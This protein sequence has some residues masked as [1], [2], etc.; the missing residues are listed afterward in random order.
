MLNDEKIVE[1]Q[2]ELFLAQSRGVPQDHILLLAFFNRGKLKITK[3]GIL[4][5]IVC[6]AGSRHAVPSFSGHCI[7]AMTEAA[8]GGW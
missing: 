6:G 8:T 7:E 5:G 2:H 1:R 4:C 3:S